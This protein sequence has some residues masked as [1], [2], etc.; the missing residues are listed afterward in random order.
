MKSTKRTPKKKEVENDSDAISD[1]SVTIVS[2]GRDIPRHVFAE[3]KNILEKEAVAGLFGY[4]RGGQ[5]QNGHAQ[6][7]V[8]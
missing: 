8:R 3:L 6:G 7:I 1:F 5:E 2:P 4:E